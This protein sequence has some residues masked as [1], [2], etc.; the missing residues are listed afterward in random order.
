MKEV[1]QKFQNAIDTLV[2]SYDEHMK[3]IIPKPKMLPIRISVKIESKGFYKIDNIHIKPYDNL[4]DLLKFI[5]E[6]QIKKGDPIL[7]WN[8]EKLV[9]IINGPLAGNKGNDL[10]QIDDEEMNQSGSNS[11]T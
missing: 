2:Q 11:L 4:N 8:K 7:K 10:M 9:F 5:E 6:H 1:E 3:H